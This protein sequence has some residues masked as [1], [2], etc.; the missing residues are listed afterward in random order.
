MRIPAKGHS[1]DFGFEP[2]LSDDFEEPPSDF[3]PES[4]FDDADS[5]ADLSAFAASLYDLLR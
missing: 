3:V 4:D 5:A 1:F 2:L